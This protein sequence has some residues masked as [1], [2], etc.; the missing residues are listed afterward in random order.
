M[1]LLKTIKILAD[2]IDE[3]HQL[4]RT[5]QV[6][7]FRIYYTHV[8]FPDSCQSVCG[9][10]LSL[11]QVILTPLFRE[12]APRISIPKVE[13]FALLE[14]YSSRPKCG[15]K[16]WGAGGARQ[17]EVQGFCIISYYSPSLQVV[18]LID[19][20]FGKCPD[21]W[22]DADRQAFSR[23]IRAFKSIRKGKV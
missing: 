23:M 20:Y 6:F 12:I 15:E 14:Y 17:H 13:Y 21:G 8:Y 7:P 10:R 18:A 3:Y 9:T 5:F 22:S 1:R 11:A 2:S 4:L 16:I 19:I